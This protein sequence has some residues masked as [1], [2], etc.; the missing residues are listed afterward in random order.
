[1]TPSI[2][3]PTTVAASVRNRVE[4]VRRVGVPCC[5][6]E[7][8]MKLVVD[9]KAL[10]FINTLQTNR[11]DSGLDPVEKFIAQLERLILLTLA[12]RTSEQIGLFS[13]KCRLRTKFEEPFH[14]LV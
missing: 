2:N 8:E 1:V 6:S 3:T 7:D 14:F 10:L 12:K 5:I 9:D 4:V 13:R 11:F